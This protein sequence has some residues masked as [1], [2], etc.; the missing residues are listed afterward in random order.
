MLTLETISFSGPSPPERNGRE[1]DEIMDAMPPL[2]SPSRRRHQASLSNDNVPWSPASVPPL[3]VG[4]L[5]ATPLVDQSLSMYFD[6]LDAGM[7]GVEWSPFQLAPS[8]THPRTVSPANTGQQQGLAGH[9]PQNKS[10]PLN[11]SPSQSRHMASDS[12]TEMI[13]D[14]QH[15]SI[16]QCTAPPQQA[17]DYRS[18]SAIVTLDQNFMHPGPWSDSKEGWRSDHFAPEELFTN[19]TLSEISREWLLMIAQRLLRVA[20]DIHGLT[21][22]SPSPASPDSDDLTSH[23]GFMRLPPSAE[24]HKYLEIVLRNY[25]PFYPLI[26]ARMLDPN[27]LADP[28][29]GRGSSLLLFL[30]FAFGA[31]LQPAVKAQRLSTALT[32]ICRHS[33]HELL[34]KNTGGPGNGL[35]FYS[36]LLFTLKSAFGG[37]KSHMNISIAHRRIYITSMRSASLFKKRSA[38]DRALPVGDDHLQ[39]AWQSWVERES[40]SRLAYGWVM[41]ENEISLFYDC[42]PILNTSELEA[43]M[44]ADESVWLASSAEEW[45]QAL[46][47]IT[48]TTDWQHALQVQ[49]ELSLRS[50]FQLLMDDQLDRPG[51]QLHLLHMRLLLYPLH[52]LVSQLGQLLD[53]G[54][55]KLQA[56]E[57]SHPIT[58]SASMIQFREIMSLLQTWFDT[59]DRLTGSGARFSAMRNATLILYHTIRLNLGTSFH[60][61]ERLARRGVVDLQHDLL[62]EIILAPE[63]AIIQCGQ[64]FRLFNQMQDELRPIWSP[65]AIYRATLTLWVVAILGPDHRSAHLQQ[66]TRPISGTSAELAIDKLPMNDPLVQQYLRVGEASPYLAAG[67]ARVFLD[68]PMKI[69]SLGIETLSGRCPTTSFSEGV[70]WKLETMTKAWDST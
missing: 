9:S 60:Q 47:R 40:V 64:I 37:D 24:L 54:L 49:S 55:T 57:F 56:R 70:R 26:P 36:A 59:F 7:F 69:L 10:E 21:L 31:M 62:D 1:P 46:C 58:Q 27:Q 61:I 50:L 33:M 15:W 4:V 39:Q 68:D 19:V 45:R 13:G 29:R 20:M 53:C 6:D 66:T 41:L 42:Q 63:D 25:E 5:S 14:W 52:L 38:P 44:P 16:C 23:G 48:S 65:V 35:L 32:E 18:K 11:P 2:M 22:D 30:M 8:L 12:T 43:N 28:K 67:N 51:H 34:E 17:A 3:G